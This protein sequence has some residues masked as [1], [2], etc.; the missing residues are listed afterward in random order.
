MCMCG[1]IYIYK[2]ILYLQKENWPVLN[3]THVKVGPPNKC[4]WPCTEAASFHPEGL[5]RILLHKTVPAAQWQNH[6]VKGTEQCYMQHAYQTFL[7][8]A[9]LHKAKVD[10]RTIINSFMNHL[11]EAR[12]WCACQYVTAHWPFK[13]HPYWASSAG[14]SKV[15]GAWCCLPDL[16]HHSLPFLPELQ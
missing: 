8:E 9:K 13:W 12:K 1:Y 16:R 3:G 4:W 6:R 15:F 11:S 14:M 5:L 10:I 2:H 7:F